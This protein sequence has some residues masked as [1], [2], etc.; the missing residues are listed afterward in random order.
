MN[1]SEKK[2]LET[3]KVGDKV[4]WTS[5]GYVKYGIVTS[6]FNRSGDNLLLYHCEYEA[7]YMPLGVSG[8]NWTRD[9]L[10]KVQPDPQL[11][12]F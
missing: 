1:R 4:K 9:K 7:P 3:I 5:R 8:V 12:L 6:I 10:T 11:G 2:E